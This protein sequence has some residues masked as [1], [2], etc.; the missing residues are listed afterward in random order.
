MTTKGD[1]MTTK[2]DIRADFT[3]ARFLMR[4]WER[5]IKATPDDLET[6][7]DIANELVACASTP[8]GYLEERGIDC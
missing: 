4:E 3:H 7:R 8:T 5:V 6:L 1:L 2:G